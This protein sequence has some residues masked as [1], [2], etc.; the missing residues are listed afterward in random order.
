MYTHRGNEA[1]ETKAMQ[2]NHCTDNSLL[3]YHRTMLQR[4]RVDERRAEGVGRRRGDADGL[5]DLVQV[6]VQRSVR[7][8]LRRQHQQPTQLGVRRKAARLRLLQQGVA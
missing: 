4:T 2:P 6:V 8:L 3:F 1:F 5:A 7:Q